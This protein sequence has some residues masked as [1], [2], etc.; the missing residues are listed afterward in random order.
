MVADPV[1]R[2]AHGPLQAGHRDGLAETAEGGG[3]EGAHR[4]LGIIHGREADGDRVGIRR[5]RAE[6][7]QRF[8]PHLGV[9]MEGEPAHP[10]GVRH[11]AQPT[12]HL[13]QRL[14]HLGR[15]GRGQQGPDRRDR[16]GAEPHEP[17]RGEE[18]APIAGG[19]DG[20]DHIDHC[21]DGAEV[22]QGAD[23]LS[24]DDR[25]SVVEPL[26]QE[27]YRIGSAQP[28]E[29]AASLGAAGR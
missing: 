26:D 27:A 5:D 17:H 1:G 7:A 19:I 21:L 15:A 12:A 13:E 20:A 24:P 10:V 6:C 11:A 2:V 28:S 9:V 14:E 18:V 4:P 22:G 29:Q 25:R 23:R 8:D 16:P 3:G